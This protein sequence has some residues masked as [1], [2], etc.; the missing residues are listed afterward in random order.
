MTV[1]FCIGI[2]CFYSFKAM[3]LKLKSKFDREQQKL[4]WIDAVHKIKNT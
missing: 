1:G 2:I 3:I 4:N